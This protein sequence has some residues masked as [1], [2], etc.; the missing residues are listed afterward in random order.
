MGVMV[1]IQD[2]NTT[3]PKEK[4]PVCGVGKQE[5][6]KR[7]CQEAWMLVTGRSSSA[8]CNAL[9]L[10]STALTT[11]GSKLRSIL[12]RLMLH[13]VSDDASV[14]VEMDIIHGGNATPASRPGRTRGLP[15][16]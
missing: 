6:K 4:K 1:G 16:R 11:S 2:R 9:S 12:M 10:A 3:R 8:T 7:S 13:G 15:H 14:F 5:D